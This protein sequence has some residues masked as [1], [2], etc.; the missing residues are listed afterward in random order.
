MMSSSRSLNRLEVK[1]WAPC[2]SAPSAEALQQSRQLQHDVRE[3][4]DED[5]GVI[6]LYVGSD[7]PSVDPGQRL[8]AS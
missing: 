3:V 7:V 1:A 8:A 4:C 2:P 5:R 6:R